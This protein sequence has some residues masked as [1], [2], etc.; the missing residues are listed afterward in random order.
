M[1]PRAG[2]L[3]RPGAGV[4]GE[5]LCQ[6]AL[7]R[8]LETRGDFYVLADWAEW[9]PMSDLGEVAYRSGEY[10]LVKAHGSIDQSE[11]G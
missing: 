1:P 7:R 11:A 8:L 10:V 3:R 4:G 5:C 9:Q 2:S 6:Q